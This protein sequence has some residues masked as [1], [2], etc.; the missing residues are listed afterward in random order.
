[1]FVSDLFVLFAIL[2]SMFCYF[3][4]KYVLLFYKMI[5][6][7]KEMSWKISTVVTEG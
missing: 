7:F 6:E 5:S 4:F 3:T 1:M 2:L